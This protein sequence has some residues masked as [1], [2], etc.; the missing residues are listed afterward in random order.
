MFSRLPALL[1]E[2]LALTDG[3][4]TTSFQSRLGPMSWIRPYT[5]R[6]LPELAAA[7]HRRLAVLCPAFVADCLETLEE[8]GIRL[9]E[10]WRALGG[11]EMLLV[12]NRARQQARGTALKPGQGEL[13]LFAVNE[14][15]ARGKRGIVR[16]AMR[17]GVSRIESGERYALGI[18][19]HD[20]A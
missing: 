11:G 4:H 13:V 12:E 1:S 5:D 10:Q 20:A 6:L 16:A 14:R 15:P 17:H 7:G 8:I 9:R 18:I 2:A 3:R 19:F